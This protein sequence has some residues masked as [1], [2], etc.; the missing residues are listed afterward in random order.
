MIYKVN[1]TLIPK[2]PASCT[3]GLYFISSEESGR[4]T[5]DGLMN[6]EDIAKKRKLSGI[7]WAYP[8]EAEARSV[9]AL[10]M[11][12]RIMTLQYDDLLNGLETREFYM[13]DIS[14]PVYRWSDSMKICTQLGFDLVER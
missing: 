6:I 8:T 11:A 5:Q 2:T 1:G 13:S 7:S 9:L 3:W 4:N 14:A 12:K 10:F